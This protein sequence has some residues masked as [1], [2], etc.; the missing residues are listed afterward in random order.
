MRFLNHFALDATI[1]VGIEESVDDSSVQI[2]F[3][4][5][6]TCRLSVDGIK[7]IHTFF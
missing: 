5:I 1:E 7:I 2:G 3:E 4:I 6:E